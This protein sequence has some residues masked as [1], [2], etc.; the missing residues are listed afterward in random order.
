M[1]FPR[2]LL[3]LT[4]LFW[5]WQTQLWAI[6]LPLAAVTEA[7]YF[8]PTRWDLADKDFR[9]IANL[10]L[11]LML[12]LIV[13]MVVIQAW[14]GA[15][16]LFLRWQP[17][18]FLPM[19]AVQLYAQRDDLSLRTLFPRKPPRSLIQPPTSIA[20][21]PTPPSKP[22][23][24][25]YPYFALCLLAASVSPE[26]SP[27]FYL[28]LVLLSAPLLWQ[29]RS[30][31]F[32]PALWSVLFVLAI[33]LGFVGHQGLRQLHLSL[34]QQ[35]IAW[36][37][38]AF[39]VGA[40][41]F[42]SN[43]AIGSIETLKQSNAILLRVAGDRAS[44]SNPTVPERLRQATYNRYNSSI[45]VAMESTFQPLR[46]SATGEQWWLTDIPSQQPMLPA[47]LDSTTLST[48]TVTAPFPKGR[49]V[50][51]LPEGTVQ[52]AVPVTAEMEMEQNQYRTV[53]VEGSNNVL[54]YQ[55][56]VVPDVFLDGL[57]TALDLEVPK[58][59]EAILTQIVEELGLT[60]KPPQV[61]VQAVEQFF[62][63]N[64]DYSLDLTT[65]AGEGRTAIANFLL[66]SRTGHCEYFATATTL[67]LRAAGIP[68]RYAIGFSVHEFSPLENQ[69]IVRSRHAHAWTLAYVNGT[70][71]TIDTTPPTW[72]SQE[73]S[74]VA[75]WGK[76]GDFFS[77]GQFQLAMVVRSLQE[78]ELFQ[79][80]WIL[81]LIWALW[82][83]WRQW[84]SGSSIKRATLQAE[85]SV[86]TDLTIP[87][88]D[89]TFYQIEQV[90]ITQGWTRLPSETFKQW[91]DRIER[92]WDSDCSLGDLKALL[93]LHYRYR[94]DPAGV[95]NHDR[96][97]L[98]SQLQQWLQRYTNRVHG[99]A[100]S[101]H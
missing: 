46:A 59:E 22:L 76:V 13:Y 49:G 63:Q 97:Q 74:M 69:Y 23:D 41:P 89:S 71:Q 30:P 79:Y 26:R 95:G 11:L 67:L 54:T 83:L 99:S 55:A 1:T 68:A 43:T 32:S 12:G 85:T 77:W 34:E 86:T 7:S 98:R 78:S 8:T 96:E 5:G 24:F 42:Q 21:P 48:I 60:G 3:G 57:P 75:I 20:T 38:E 6:A 73:D 28:G 15:I 64:F 92:S 88:T 50:L 10:S 36:L 61:I 16:A 45:W 87:G 9:R 18:L 19:V 93:I 47:Q 14:E 33:G 100:N 39:G 17:V 29:M 56:Q 70:W 37:S 84:R 44:V 82:A 101:H 35:A 4:L 91:L 80:W 40:D 90:L 31:R 2:L 27:L 58:S 94:F 51:K 53:K 81:I 62:L 25:R 52:V 65:E 72:I 66:D